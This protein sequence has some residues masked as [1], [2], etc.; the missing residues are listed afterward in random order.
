MALKAVAAVEAARGMFAGEQAGDDAVF[1]ADTRRDHAPDVV[2]VAR[3]P[4]RPASV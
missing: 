2:R 1:G 4:F 3:P